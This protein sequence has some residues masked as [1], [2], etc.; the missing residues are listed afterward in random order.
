MYRREKTLVIIKPGVSYSNAIDIV[1]KIHKDNDIV[2]SCCYYL[3]KNMI[4]ELYSHIVH[5]ECFPEI[6]SYM[7]SSRSWILI[8]EGENTIEKTRKIA[9]QIRKDGKTD[10]HKNIIHASD[11]IDSAVKE[12][13][14]IEKWI[15]RYE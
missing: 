8:L 14:L 12:V 9:L 6:L 11:C 4:N 10:R 13:S 1:N 7:T 15:Y 2:F 3:T 5:L